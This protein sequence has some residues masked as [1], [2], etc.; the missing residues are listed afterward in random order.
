MSQEST[1]D[2]LMHL[3]GTSEDR[4]GNPHYIIKNSWNHNSNDF[5]GKLHMSLPFVKAKTIAIMVHKDAV[6]KKLR[7]KLDF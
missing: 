6:P 5:Q 3:I 1:D 7:K 2:H 4:E